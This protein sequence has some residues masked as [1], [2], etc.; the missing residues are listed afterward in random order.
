[1]SK[2]LTYKDL[3]NFKRSNKMRCILN[4]I[5]KE[6]ETN[7]TLILFGEGVPDNERPDNPE[8]VYIDELTG[9][10][11]KWDNELGED[12]KWYLVIEFATRQWVDEIIDN[13]EYLEQ[14]HIN[15]KTFG[16]VGDGITDDTIAIQNTIDFA[17]D[18]GFIVYIPNGEYKISY[19]DI[20]L[21]ENW[22]DNYN[23]RNQL[24]YCLTI[25]TGTQIEGQSKEAI[26]KLDKTSFLNAIPN[27][28][29]TGTYIIAEY[30]NR[31]DNVSVQNITIDGARNDEVYIPEMDTL[32][33]NGYNNYVNNVKI[34]NSIGDAIDQDY[35]SSIIENSIF[36][37]V[38]TAVN[39]NTD[40]GGELLEKCIINNNEVVL[41]NVAFQIRGHNYIIKNNIIKN[42]ESYG[43]NIQTNNSLGLNETVRYYTINNNSFLNI[44]SYNI[45]YKAS[46]IDVFLIIQN[47][48][49][50]NSKLILNTI[51]NV[52]ELLNITLLN[53]K[54]LNN[55]VVVNT[56]NNMKAVAIN[57]IFE[58]IPT[59]FDNFDI[60]DNIIIL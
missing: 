32:G 3:Q 33:L 28:P 53:N 1:M 9:D 58:T 15:V 57:N 14:S 50:L 12:G 36:E 41:A 40:N 56:S 16:A 54:C 10:L 19:Q 24:V 43:V 27:V 8:S 35:G 49:F 23:V 22:G 52:N 13:L 60:V 29:T 5:V 46:G 17:R 45:N 21:A 30:Q 44:N 4:L 39:A 42:T 34:I 25:Y 7:A 48:I 37:N 6:Y 26:L 11:Y 55:N 2:I 51:G 20:I 38:K 31:V 47:N 18:N 59:G